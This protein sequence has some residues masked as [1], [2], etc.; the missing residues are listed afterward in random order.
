MFLKSLC[1]DTVYKSVRAGKRLGSDHTR[2][3]T[4]VESG[5]CAM[6]VG[7]SWAM[8]MNYVVRIVTIPIIG[9]DTESQG[10]YMTCIRS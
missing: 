1:L 6:L 2:P 9:V 3:C 5:F 10:G 8:R 4:S 7:K